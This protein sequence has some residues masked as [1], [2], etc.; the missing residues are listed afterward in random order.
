VTAITVANTDWS[1]V[2]AVKSALADATIAGEKAFRTV[3]IALS[4]TQAAETQFRRNTPLAA[5]I[6]DDT[7]EADCLEHVKAL[8]VRM[9]ILLAARLHGR[10]SEATR[11]KEGLRLVNTAKNAVE[12]GLPADAS[13]WGHGNYYQP[14]IEWGTPDIERPTD[15][16]RAPWVVAT[17]GLTVGATIENATS[18]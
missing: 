10:T 18:H 2:N 15:Q 1:I 13:A 3:T 6:Y 8:R 11:L 16:E 7:S 17:L 4:Q 5:V 14:Q 9:T 12:S